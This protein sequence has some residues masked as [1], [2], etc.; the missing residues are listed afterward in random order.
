[1]GE[2]GVR[3]LH[4]IVVNL[5]APIVPDV[6]NE[7]LPI[8][9]R[10][11]RIDHHSDIPWGS[12]ELFIPA[13][14]PVVGPRSLRAPVHKQKQGVLLRGIKTRRADEQSLDTCAIRPLEPE[15]L[16]GGSPP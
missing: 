8:A 7:L 13:V 1:M 5:S 2:R 14:A 4:Q 16:R 9:R 12:E 15:R 10:A 11:A 6:V 3:A